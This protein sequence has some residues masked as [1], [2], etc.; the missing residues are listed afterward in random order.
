MRT[1]PQK[2]IIDD[3]RV[4]EYEERKGR[5]LIRLLSELQWIKNAELDNDKPYEE[6]RILWRKRVFFMS[7]G[8]SF[9]FSLHFGL[10]LLFFTFT[11]L[12]GLLSP[13]AGEVYAV[14][15]MLSKSLLFALFPTWLIKS[16]HVWDRGIT[17]L[18]LKDVIFWGYTLGM[19]I[20]TFGVF[21]LNLAEVVVLRGLLATK[22][23]WIAWTYHH[24]PFLFSFWSLIE[25]PIEV[26]L[27]T[28]LPY[29]Y[30]K[31]KDKENKFEVKPYTLLDEVPKE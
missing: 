22:K 11:V 12:F 10:S 3:Y 7:I 4:Q 1:S 26:V 18:V 14:F 25:Y 2:R 17:R 13:K 21:F 30:L 8:W 6:K 20:L 28:L 9:A 5:G 31:K 23:E 29:W 16:F 19:I 27:V 15:A 24:L